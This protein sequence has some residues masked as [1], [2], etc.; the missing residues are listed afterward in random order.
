MPRM[1]LLCLLLTISLLNPL[2]IIAEP[3]TVISSRRT[4]LSGAIVKVTKLDGTSYITSLDYKGKLVVREVPLGVVLLQLIEWKGV[5]I[6]VTY[7]VT[8]QNSTVTCNKIGELIIYVKG[9]RGQGLN[10]ATIVIMWDGKTI[11]QG[12]SSIDGSY[13]TELPEG[14]YELRASFGGKKII[15]KVEVV[16]GVVLETSVEL[17]VFLTIGGLTLGLYEFVGV[18]VGLILLVIILFIL[19]YEYRIWRRKRLVAR[20]LRSK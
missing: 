3:I 19:M 17:D 7:V 9:L 1:L 11:E 20:A 16:G 15:T 5:P 10:G 2:T 14:L 6:N 12:Y 18:I 4:P 8:L 13:I